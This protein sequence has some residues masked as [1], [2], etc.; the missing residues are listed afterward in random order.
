MS[1]GDGP[2]DL[3]LFSGFG[4]FFQP[5]WLANGGFLKGYPP[6]QRFYYF[7]A[8]FLGFPGETIQLLGS[9]IFGLPQI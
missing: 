6:N 1:Y 4:P 2:L 7:Y 5:F 8:M 3:W 9:P